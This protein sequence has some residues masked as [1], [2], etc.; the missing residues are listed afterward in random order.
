MIMLHM[1]VVIVNLLNKDCSEWIA[2]YKNYE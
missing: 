2:G 1:N